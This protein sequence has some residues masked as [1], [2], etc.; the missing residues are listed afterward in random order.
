MNSLDTLTDAFTELERRADAHAA[1]SATTQLPALHHS[2]APLIAASVVVTLAVA[3]GAAVL[4]SAGSDRHPQH[5]A[6]APATQNA[7]STTTAFVIPQTP[8]ELAARFRTVLG[9][10]ATFT[11]TDTGTPGIGIAPT[12][13]LQSAV[14]EQV[15]TERNLLHRLGVTDIQSA[16]NA[17]PASNGA[18]IIGTLTSN[19]VT[20]GYDIQILQ[21]E[22]GS[23]AMCD[24]PDKARCTLSTTSDG[25]SL[26]VGRE[27]LQGAPDAVTYQVDLIRGDGVEFLMHV[28]NE[29]DPKGA[30]SVLAPKPPLTTDQMVSIVTSDRW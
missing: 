19:G 22:P 28:S 8:D 10:L 6:G 3:G 4:A 2:R 21:N 13:A 18:A 11:V 30:S 15:R 23:K 7:A 12:R 14:R 17:A 16:P 24:D 27:P 20:G 25:G 29:R 1:D 9:D 26:A 5:P